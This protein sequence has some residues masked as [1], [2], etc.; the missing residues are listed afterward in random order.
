[1]TD[2]IELKISPVV[3]IK[4]IHCLKGNSINVVLHPV[5]PASKSVSQGLL[6]KMVE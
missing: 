6:G 2:E 3:G 1:M 4:H 5:T